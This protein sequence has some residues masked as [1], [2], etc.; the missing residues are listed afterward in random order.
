[1]D[2]PVINLFN[3]LPKE[4]IDLIYY[5]LDHLTIIS[6]SLTCNNELSYLQRRL[7]HQ[8]ET[9]YGV[10]TDYSVNWRSVHCSLSSGRTYQE[11][12]DEA[13]VLRDEDVIT[14][15]LT[16]PSIQL[17]PDHFKHPNE[18]DPN[19][20]VNII[21]D[22]DYQRHLQLF[23]NVMK[24]RC[25]QIKFRGVNG[26]LLGL[27]MDP[28]NIIVSLCKVNEIKTFQSRYSGTQ[29]EVMV[30]ILLVVVILIHDIISLISP[31]LYQTRGNTELLTQMWNDCNLSKY[32]EKLINHSVP[33]DI[34]QQLGSITIT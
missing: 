30:K 26:T 10:T 11:I 22:F 8:C 29:I 3:T 4:L 32:V 28:E 24:S 31:H 19:P 14:A 2:D 18:S 9:L 7:K 17:R 13:F 6:W 33:Q 15:L 23:R 12:F 16:H 21:N 5:Q 1:M 34:L 27:G 25:D 20:M